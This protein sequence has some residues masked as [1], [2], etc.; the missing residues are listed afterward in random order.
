[1]KRFPVLSRVSL[2]SLTCDVTYKTD[3]FLQ[4]L[5]DWGGGGGVL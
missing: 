5:N 2:T 1:M 4:D 3:C